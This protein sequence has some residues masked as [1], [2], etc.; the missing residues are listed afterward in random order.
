LIHWRTHS[1]LPFVNIASFVAGQH[2]V[3]TI[4]EGIDMPCGAIL[5]P[6]AKQPP[7]LQATLYGDPSV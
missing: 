1:N 3:M 7:G 2:L 5:Q 4:I 6:I